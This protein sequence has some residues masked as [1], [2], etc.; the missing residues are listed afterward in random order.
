MRVSILFESNKTLI[1]IVTEL[2]L[3][4]RKL[5]FLLIFI[6]QSYLKVLKIIRLNATDHFVIKISNKRKLQK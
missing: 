3:R 6:L 5:N 4:G 2:F 1:P